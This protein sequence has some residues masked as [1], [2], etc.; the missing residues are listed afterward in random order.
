[1][2]AIEEFNKNANDGTDRE[3]QVQLD[4]LQQLCQ[5]IEAA[6]DT[7][8]IRQRLDALIDYSE[9]H[10]MSEELLMRM[11]SY[12]QHEEH[13]D[14]HDHMLEVLHDLAAKNAAGQSTL[15]A[16]QAR[17]MLGFISQHIATRDR[18]LADYVHNNL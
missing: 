1:M 18:R 5:A 15:M 14:D 10:F 2:S 17:D 6:E 13:Q 3:H 16:G 8:S 4:L 9:A 12:D 7:A 11:K